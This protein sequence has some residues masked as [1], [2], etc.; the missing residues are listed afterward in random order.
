MKVTAFVGSARKKHTYNAAEKFLQNLQSLGN[1]DYE[2]VRLSECKLGTCRGCILCLDRGEELCQ[3]RDDRDALIGKMMESD[4]VIFASPNYSFNVSGIMKVFLDRLGFM[5]HRPR[6]FG[7][8]F[9]SIVAQ[10]IFRGEEIVKYFDF[11]GYALGFNVVRGS[12]ITTL[13]PMTEAAMKKTDAIIERQ[14]RKFYAKL[15]KKEYP[16]PS[17]VKLMMFRWAR[18]SIRSRLTEEY[19]DFRYYRDQGWFE[20]DYFYPVKLNPLKKL[21]GRFFDWMGA[22]TAGKQ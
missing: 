5:F 11:I 9:T 7:K 19:K 14:S 18:S 21:A 2:I 13:E 10:G 15:I 6:F 4:G 16:V 22:K 12:C 17:L 3:F 8:T 1:V 20:T